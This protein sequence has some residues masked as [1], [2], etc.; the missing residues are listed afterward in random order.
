MP[1]TQTKAEELLVQYQTKLKSVEEGLNTTDASKYSPA[2][3]L[4]S[5]LLKALPVIAQPSTA[6]SEY[7][8]QK[9]QTELESR[10]NKQDEMKETTFA[11]LAKKY[12]GRAEALTTL[13][14]EIR[15]GLKAEPVD[16]VTPIVEESATNEIGSSDVEHED[17]EMASVASENES[18][19]SSENDDNALA[20]NDI[21]PVRTSDGTLREQTAEVEEPLPFT[22][23]NNP[24]IAEQV[25]DGFDLSFWVQ[26]GLL[27]AGFVASIALSVAATMMANPVLLGAGVVATAV[28]GVA[29]ARTLGLF[30]TNT[31]ASDLI[32]ISENTTPVA[33]STPS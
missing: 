20:N 32:Q 10:F 6:S 18:D 16:E 3:Q 27:G 33:S 23:G 19:V 21:A 9:A 17:E 30:N 14:N 31:A 24:A 7:S 2:S 5:T 26:A 29:L 4:L 11:Y 12:D 13:E 15:E 22:R 1:M 28:S 8:V 25:V